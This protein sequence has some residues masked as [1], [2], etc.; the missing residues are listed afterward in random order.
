MKKIKQSAELLDHE[1]TVLSVKRWVQAFVI[2][3]NLCPFAKHE[4]LNKRVRFATTKA[5]TEAKLL[6]SLQDE[7]ELLNDDPSIETTLLIHSNVLQDFNSYNQF[8][9]C[10]DKL[11]FDMDLE[12]IYQLASFHPNYQFSG[13]CVDD[14]E[15]YTNRSPYPLL[16]LIREESLERAI[17]QHPDI[18]QVPIQNMAL[19]N[20][21]GRTKLEELF[22]NLFK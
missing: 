19:M 20:S 10:A 22:E 4:I 16:H 7:L 17:S 11:L 2:E 5:T 1:K 6:K 15:N 3:M 21:L 9:N 18:D 8:L 14:T 12:G 13:T